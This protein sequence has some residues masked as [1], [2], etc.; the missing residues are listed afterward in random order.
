KAAD[1]ARR[2]ERTTRSAVQRSRPARIIAAAPPGNRRV[3]A[4]AAPFGSFPASAVELGARAAPSPW[5]G[6]PP[7]GLVG[8]LT[9]GKVAGRRA[10]PHD[11]TRPPSLRSKPRIQSRGPE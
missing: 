2:S 1:R 9:N 3:G 10:A 7:D 8:S 11:V 4:E 6:R 5:F